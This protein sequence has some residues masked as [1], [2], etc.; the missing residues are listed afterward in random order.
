MIDENRLDELELLGNS[1]D[2]RRLVRLGLLAE[3][4]GLGFV[5]DIPELIRYKMQKWKSRPRRISKKEAEEIKQMI[6]RK[7]NDKAG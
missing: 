7:M 6:E 3:K 4:L 2:V 5:Y 1:A